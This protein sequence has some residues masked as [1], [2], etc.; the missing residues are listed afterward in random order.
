MCGCR[1]QKYL[2]VPGVVKVNEY[3]PSV[4]STLERNVLGDT[5][6]WGMS[7]SFVQVTVLPALTFSSCG[8]KVKLPILTAISS[9]EAGAAAWRYAAATPATSSLVRALIIVMAVLTSESACR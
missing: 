2:K 6:V 3:F 8:P 5:T 4:S 9:A 1:E 7:S